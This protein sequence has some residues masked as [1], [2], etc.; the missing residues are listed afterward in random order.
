M[1]NTVSDEKLLASLKRIERFAVL[2]DSC[3]RIPFT[4]IRF[5]LD[6]IIG[7]VPVVGELVG[8]VLSMYLIVESYKLKLPFS[9][10]LKMLGNAALDFI[11]GIIPFVGDIADVAFKANIRNMEILLAYVNREYEKR[12]QPPENSS[13]NIMSYVGLFTLI[14]AVLCVSV[15]LMLHF[16]G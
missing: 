9:L 6:S 5:G 2:T 1:E 3:F 10:K 13:N 8:F 4:S 7:V 11:I 12:H 15:F 14:V 16:F